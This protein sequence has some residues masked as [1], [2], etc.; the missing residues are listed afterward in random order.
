MELPLLGEFL[1][2]VLVEKSGSKHTQKSYERDLV[3]FLD[4]L[5]ASGAPSETQFSQVKLQQ[6]CTDRKLGRR[7]Q[8]RI[9]S[10]LR[11]YFKYLLRNGRISEIPKLEIIDHTRGLPETL[12]EDQ[13]NKLLI[14]CVAGE[15]NTSRALRN[16]LVMTLL[17]ATGCRVTELCTVDL[18][19]VQLDARLMRIS[20]KGSKERVV[21]LVKEAFEILSE[22]LDIRMILSHPLEK[23]LLV[24]DRGHRP[25]RIDIFRWLKK[26][27]K[28]AG[29]E[30][31]VSPHKLRHA[32]ATH[33]LREGV[34]LR[35]IQILLGHAN[36]ATTEIYTRVENADLEKVVREYHPLAD[37]TLKS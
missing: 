21:P 1:T 8:A 15:E 37:E 17:Y 22:Y 20:G 25:S 4:F 5:G 11:S 24:N 28:L 31:N 12:S 3:L 6:F 10:T 23:S 2:S 19:D 35:S 18:A 13:I 7:S 9:I 34:D 14:A 33:L 30:K 27:S 36:I 16:K 26:W 29:F 32:C